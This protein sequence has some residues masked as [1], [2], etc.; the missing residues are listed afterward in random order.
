MMEWMFYHEFFPKICDLDMPIFQDTFQAQ[1]S[2]DMLQKLFWYFV[3]ILNFPKLTFKPCFNKDFS[4][5]EI[6]LSAAIF[7][8]NIKILDILI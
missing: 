2:N 5:T 8:E 3:Q 7:T 6:A 1:M 4:A